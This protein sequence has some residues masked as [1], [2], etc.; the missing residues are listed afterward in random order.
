MTVLQIRTDACRFLVCFTF[1]VFRMDG[2]GKIRIMC[3]GDEMCAPFPE[4]SAGPGRAFPMVLENGF[5]S[6]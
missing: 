5:R 3:T 4:I 6:E 2:A 1:P